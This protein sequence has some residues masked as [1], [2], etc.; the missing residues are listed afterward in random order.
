ME[1]RSLAY[2]RKEL[3]QKRQELEDF[4]ERYGEKMAPEIPVPY[5]YSSYSIR[6]EPNTL[7]YFLTNEVS[8]VSTEMTDFAK[9]KNQNL[10]KL[11]KAATKQLEK[12]EE[13]EQRERHEI[14][15][16]Q[17]NMAKTMSAA[18]YKSY[19]QNVFRVLK[20]LQEKRFKLKQ[21]QI[22]EKKINNFL[23]VQ[24]ELADEILQEIKSSNMSFV[25]PAKLT[26]LSTES[27]EKSIII[28]LKKIKYRKYELKSVEEHERP[29]NEIHDTISHLDHDRNCPLMLFR[30]KLR[31]YQR[32]GV[33]WLNTLGLKRISCILAD[34]MGLGKTVQ[35][36]A[37]FAYLA[38]VHGIWGPHLV[39]VPTTV[40]GNW[41]NEFQRFLPAMKVFAYYGR[42]ADRKQK[43]KGWSELDKFN[44]CLTTYR[45][46][47]IDAK[48][49]KRRRWFTMILDEAHIIKNP[50]TQ[51]FITLQKIKTFN[52][53]LLTGTPLQNRLQ[54]LWTLMTFLFPKKFG[55]KN[56]FCSNFD[57]YLEK[58]AKTNSNA[59]NSIIKKLHSILRPLILRRLKKDVE[60]Q[61][62]K[63]IEKVVLCDLSRRQKLLYDQ[64]IMN[65][66]ADE[67]KMN[68][69]VQSLN[70]LMQLR[71]ICNHPDL[72]DEKV[73]QSAMILEQ[74]E[75]MVP[76]FIDFQAFN[77]RV[78]GFQ[79]PLVREPGPL[80]NVYL[81]GLICLLHKKNRDSMTQSQVEMEYQSLLRKNKMS[82]VAQNLTRCQYE[83]LIPFSHKDSHLMSLS[84]Q[85]A[86]TLFKSVADLCEWSKVE[87]DNFIIP[88]IPVAST[89]FYSNLYKDM[90][91]YSEQIFQHSLN[92][93]T[94]IP[95]VFVNN[96]NGF[97]NDAGKM[98]KLY[99][100]LMKLRKNNK[101]VLIFTQMSKM[102]NFLEALLSAK[103]FT[104]VRL[105]GS[106]P[107]EK[108][109]A[110]V[111]YF[112][113]NP[114][115]MIFI[116]STRV[117]GIGINLTAADTVIFYDCDWNP[118]VDKQAQ[119]RCHRI[120]QNRDVTVYK[121]VSKY[122]IE[123][124]IL[125]TSNVK[126]KMDD[127]VLNK[128]KFNLQEI[129]SSI[130][131]TSEGGSQSTGNFNELIT[132]YLNQVEE[133][134]DRVNLDDKTKY[135]NKLDGG[136]VDE[137]AENDEEALAEQELEE[138][139]LFENGESPLGEINPDD[140][141]PSKM[142]G[143]KQHT[144]SDVIETYESEIRLVENVL[145]DLY[146][147]GI[148]ILKKNVVKSDAWNEP[149]GLDE[150]AEIEDEGFEQ[151]TDHSENVPE[152]E[153]FYK[154]VLAKRNLNIG[155]KETQ[156]YILETRKKFKTNFA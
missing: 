92:S 23:K 143:Q 109:Q 116:S 124:N 59:Y 21:K 75:F 96:I 126:S 64:F 22:E 9:A 82:R 101:K 6:G 137:N 12:R 156:E 76:S 14:K 56:L 105:D 3:A 7:F 67:R 40:L 60:K 19:W 44:I 102:L 154:E 54:E 94:P 132:A 32:I 73:S 133:E 97:I 69:F 5:R 36:I 89:G 112:N 93:V 31:N 110:K 33:E 37:H 149:T 140:F 85:S 155:I 79:R 151:N 71:K 42:S 63:K 87:Y 72:I 20:F 58:A 83:D 107:T 129:F 30:G 70:A 55:Q 115:I 24:S 16:R 4:R 135:K 84:T 51:C 148:K 104:Y 139:N 52:R 80:I 111:T 28:H 47:S 119:D 146:K 49:F 142:V 13:R 66:S 68:G 74:I 131:K 57:F 61:L 130:I 48:I 53:I 17:V 8:K 41:I 95:K 108:R 25:S 43:R 88:V 34:E 152:E 114:K 78:I 38:E 138:D 144:V 103:G 26:A 127:L 27:V 98:K 90:S 121:L 15:K 86:P 141:D 81:M 106:I 125:M 35:T 147:Y 117:G 29:A 100:L 118:A 120:G 145:P 134:T 50:K 128:G 136:D 18:V 62:P 1:F 10:K 65:S 2:L 150:E 123:E 39:V 45:I 46:I 122:T 153:M 77:T 99:H 91:R 113:E 11:A